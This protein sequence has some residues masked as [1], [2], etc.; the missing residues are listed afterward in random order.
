MIDG[1]IMKPFGP[2]IGIYKMPQGLIDDLNTDCLSTDVDMS[3][4]LIGNID[5]QLKFSEEVVNDHGAWFEEA[6]NHYAQSLQ[7]I[8]LPSVVLGS[9]WYNRM[10]KSLESNPSHIHGASL[11]SSVGYLKLP[12]NFKEEL[13]KPHKD[14]RGGGLHVYYGEYTPLAVCELTLV[15]DVGDYYIFPSTLRHAV[16]PLLP[17][18]NGE[19][20][21]FSINYRSN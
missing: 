6:A 2:S 20:R 16:N 18:L 10:L 5:L 19:R 21:S 4:E 8:D 17:S 7:F 3:N 12:D 11:L 1:K 9:A 13:Q 14:G 15:P